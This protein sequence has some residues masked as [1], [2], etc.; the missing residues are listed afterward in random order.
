MSAPYIPARDSTLDSWADN[1]QTLITAAPAT[2]GL[3][4]PDAVAIANAFTLWHAAFLLGGSSGSPPVPNN[5]STFTRVTVAQKNSEKIA[6]TTLYRAY[7]SQIRL[8]PGVTNGDKIALGLNLPNNTPSPIPTP[9]TFPLLAIVAAGPLQHVIRYNDSATPSLRKK[10]FGAIGMQ[11]F[12]GASEAPIVV[13]ESTG[14]LAQVTVNP[15]LSIF[16]ADNR[17]KVATYFARWITR[18]RNAG[19]ASGLVG[20]WSAAVSLLVP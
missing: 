17:G 19:G 13:P 3:T 10:P 4:A 8:N 18:G 20:P 15:Y 12:M 16:D 1:F 6:M 5:P 9:L 2:Y 7:A 11:L 14:F